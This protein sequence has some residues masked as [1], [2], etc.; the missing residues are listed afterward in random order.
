MVRLGIPSL[1]A[2]CAFLAL[3]CA[4]GNVD[5]KQHRQAL[6]ES[7]RKYSQYIRWGEFELASRYVEPEQRGEFL[8]KLEGYQKDVRFGEY[9]IRE[10]DRD[11][12]LTEASVDVSY[13]AYHMGTLVVKSFV[14]SQKWH[15]EPESSQWWLEPDIEGLQANLQSLQ[16]Y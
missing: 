6:E 13:E 2:A 16:E 12:E 3:G 1:V 10:I 9:R 4:L 15:R 7:Q 5:W 14:E 8:D 11:D